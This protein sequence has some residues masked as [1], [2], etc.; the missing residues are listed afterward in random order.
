MPTYYRPSSEIERQF[1]EFKSTLPEGITGPPP[2]DFAA[3]LQWDSWQ[4]HL[5]ELVSEHHHKS[6]EPEPHNL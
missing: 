1:A 5:Y 6:V 2:G 3:Q 4:N